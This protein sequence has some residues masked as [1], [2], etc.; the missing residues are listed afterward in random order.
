MLRKLAYMVVIGLILTT[1]FIYSDELY[2][3][4]VSAKQIWF[5]GTMALLM[6]V[7][8]IDLLFTRRSLKV[9]L[10]YIDIS[11]LA[12]YAYYAIRAAT[13]PYMPML[14]NQR[15][16]NWTLLVVMYFIITRISNEKLI[17]NSKDAKGGKGNELQTIHPHIINYSLLIS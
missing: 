14:H 15:F 16:I 3:G 7:A 8:A 11:L 10:N 12:F 17:M 1:P 9:S 6:F 4:V 5:Y 13:T 2:N